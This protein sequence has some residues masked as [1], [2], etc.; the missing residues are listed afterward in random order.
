[1]VL[2]PARLKQKPARKKRRAGQTSSHLRNCRWNPCA[3]WVYNF[4]VLMASWLPRKVA[5]MR[6]VSIACFLLL[7]CCQAGAQAPQPIDAPKTQNDAEC[8]VAGT[9]VRLDTGEPLKKATVILWSRDNGDQSEFAI[10]DAQGYF[11]FDKG[12]PGTYSLGAG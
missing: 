9:V 1:M 7:L 12:G 4:S 8:V 3:S 11:Q 2:V 6:T 10:T 5:N